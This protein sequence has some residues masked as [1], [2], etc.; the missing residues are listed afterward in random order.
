MLTRSRSF[1][2]SFP[3]PPGFIHILRWGA[4]L[5][6][7][8]WLC[9]SCGCFVNLKPPGAPGLAQAKII[10]ISRWG[11]RLSAAGGLFDSCGCFVNSKPSWATGPVQAKIINI[12]HWGARLSAAGGLYDSC[13]CSA[14][15]KLS[16][17]M[18]AGALLTL[19][20]GLLIH[21]GSEGELEGVGLAPSRPLGRSLPA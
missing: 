15:S 17:F 9:D 7:A 8:G 21:N 14:N 2:S 3:K 13:G 10:N 16:G 6:T 18:P 1:R 4:R 12:L 5:S 20:G 19:E 11:A